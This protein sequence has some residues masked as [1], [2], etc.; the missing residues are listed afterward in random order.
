MGVWTDLEG[1]IASRPVGPSWEGSFERIKGS[2]TQSRMFVCGFS[3][4][5][6]PRTQSIVATEAEGNGGCSQ[7]RRLAE[8]TTCRKQLQYKMF[9]VMSFRLLSFEGEVAMIE[10]RL[11][12]EGI[13]AVRGL[14]VHRNFR[15]LEH[16]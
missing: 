11:G 8:A 6:C 16:R 4:Q 5:E 2:P 14:F 1:Q 7:V 10:R 15:Q 3:G 13:G 9:T 12:W